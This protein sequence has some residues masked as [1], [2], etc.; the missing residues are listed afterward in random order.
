MKK[1]RDDVCRLGKCVNHPCK[2]LCAPLIFVNGKAKSKEILVS[3]LVDP[4]KIEYQNYNEVISELAEDHLH[5]EEH[6]K[7]KMLE[8]LTIPNDRDKL[9]ALAQLA[10]F[11]NEGIAGYLKLSIRRIQQLTKK[12]P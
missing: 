10:G 1:Y 8:I 6:L 4:E 3:N 11:D 7:E 5:R 2:G 9:I 12:L